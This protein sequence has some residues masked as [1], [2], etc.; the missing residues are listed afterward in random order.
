MPDA[1]VYARTKR[2]RVI[3]LDLSSP[4][5]PRGDE[6]TWRYRQCLQCKLRYNADAPKCPRCGDSSPARGLPAAAYGGFLARRDESP[7]LDEEERYAAKNL[8]EVY[9]QWGGKIAGRWT[10]GAG[11][12]LRGSQEEQVFWLNEGPKPKPYEVKAGLPVLHSEAKGFLLCPACGNVLTPTV[13]KPG[14]TGGRPQPRTRS[15]GR[16][17][18]GHRDGCS[19]AGL[20]PLPQALV[21]SSQAEVLRLLIPVPSNIRESGVKT[22]GYSLGYSLLIGMQRL[23]MI[24]ATELEFELEGPWKLDTHLQVALAFIDPS[25]GGTGYLR[26]IADE[27]N[28]VAKTAIEHLDHPNCESA[29]YRCLKSYRNQRH[30]EYLQWPLVMPHLQTL[31]DLVPISRPVEAKDID[32][33]K[34]WLEAYSAGVGSPLELQFLRLFEKYGFSPEKQVPLSVGIGLS[35]ITVADFAVPSRRLA[36]Y[37]DGAAFHVGD[38]LRRDRHIRSQLRS[39]QPPWRVEELTIKDLGKGEQLVRQLMA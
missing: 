4:W 38:N 23:Y 33:P 37:I 11:W 2:W 6:P 18:Y 19:Q 10:V 3:G 31:A 9:P 27:F 22:W 26:R 39:C 17:P 24:D 35:P 15:R 20:Q 25:L 7:V 16:D 30:H 36:I 8:V 14:R 12:A 29:C 34:P 32:D 13:S 1:Q 28:E 5:N 21:T